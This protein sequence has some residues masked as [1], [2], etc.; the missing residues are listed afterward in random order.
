MTFSDGG[1]GREFTVTI[2]S[3]LKRTP[4]SASAVSYYNSVG[5]CSASDWELNTEKECSH[6][7]ASD[8]FYC[9]YQLDGNNLYPK[10]SDGS[11]Y[12]STSDVDTD[13]ASNTYV[14]Q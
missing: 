12:P 1:T 5:K 3:T 11:S 8:T 9:L 13:N 6:D 10:C 7:D 4:Q 14:K 2:G